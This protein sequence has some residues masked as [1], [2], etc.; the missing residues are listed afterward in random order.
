MHSRRD[1]EQKRRMARSEDRF[2]PNA[3]ADY[4]GNSPVRGDGR[5]IRCQLLPCS[6]NT[7][8]FS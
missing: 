3:D 2:F 6:C 1:G 8:N 7:P 5:R 4:F